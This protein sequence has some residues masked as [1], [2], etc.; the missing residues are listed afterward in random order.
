MGEFNI[1]IGKLVLNQP[2]T[3]WYSLHPKD[4]KKKKEVS[5]SI[6]LTVQLVK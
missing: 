1:D 6:N 5:G 2:V 4:D 3:E